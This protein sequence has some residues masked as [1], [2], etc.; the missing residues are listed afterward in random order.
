MKAKFILSKKIVR[1]QL[2]KC[3]ELADE[4]SYSAKTNYEVCK[5][6]EDTDCSFSIHSKEA[7]DQIKNKSKIWFSAQ[8]WNIEEIEEIYNKGVKS[9]V[10]DN[11]KDLDI[12]IKSNKEINL[13]LRMRLKESTVHTGK[14]FVFGFY[15]KEINNLIPELRKNN[16]IK[17]LGIHFHR[18]T[19]NVS[20]WS[21][22]SE[23]EDSIDKNT[24]NSI[25]VL[26][27]GG[28]I[29]SIYKN[30]RVEALESLLIKIKE[31][32]KWLNQQNV[33]VIVEPGRYIAAPSVKLIAEVKNIYNNNIILNA[34]IYNSAMDTFIA[35]IR[36]LVEG[37]LDKGIPFV[38]KGSTP[39]SL[40]I[41]RYR[42][43]LKELP[44]IGD[45]ITFLNAGAYNFS[46]EFCNL[47]KLETEITE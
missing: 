18:K 24:L 44:K 31:L 36:L 23:L 47:P 29:P 33:K 41:F 3:Y 14:H 5:I 34:S 43:F 30:Y 45:K 6:L 1:D 9:F 39:D 37:E 15:S 20:E 42:V 21:L 40:D 25:D 2:K 7:V 17:T 35:H 16:N 8:G 27:I 22:I 10:V 38:L 12:L 19:Q 32:R 13:L 4:V 26:N 11:Q 46:T 28:G